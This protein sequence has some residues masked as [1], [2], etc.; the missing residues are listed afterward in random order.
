MKTKKFSAM[1][2]VALAVGLLVLGVVVRSAT[3]RFQPEFLDK[4]QVLKTAVTQDS[5]YSQ[6]TNHMQQE[7]FTMEPIRGTQSPFQ[8]NQYRAYLP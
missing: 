1:K 2:W 8:V 7:A 4:R 6:Q 3:E 5:S